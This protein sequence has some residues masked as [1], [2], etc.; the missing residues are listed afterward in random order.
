MVHGT[1]TLICLSTALSAF[2]FHVAAVREE[3][4]LAMAQTTQTP[5]DSLEDLKF[6][7]TAS[8][9]PHM[10]KSLKNI[11]DVDS[12][13][14]AYECDCGQGEDDTFDS[15]FVETVHKDKTFW[16]TG[17]ANTCREEHMKNTQSAFNS[18]FFPLFQPGFF[19]KVQGLTTEDIVE[20]LEKK[21]YS[22]YP[23]DTIVTAAK[24]MYGFF[25]CYAEK[26]CETWKKAVKDAYKTASC[27][28][29]NGK[30]T[31]QPTGVLDWAAWKS[32]ALPVTCFASKETEP[33]APPK[34]NDNAVNCPS[35]ASTRPIKPLSWWWAT[36]GDAPCTE[37]L[38]AMKKALGAKVDERGVPSI[39]M[40]ALFCGEEGCTAA[41]KAWWSIHDDTFDRDWQTT[42][43]FRTAM[44]SFFQC[45]AA[46]TCTRLPEG[47]PVKCAGGELAWG[48]GDALQD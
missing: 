36:E 37:E 4:G 27:D 28:N 2:V 13:D 7:H 32:F 5:P 20:K 43:E 19:M 29:V 47:S 9:M 48:L 8:V 21:P 3:T 10:D 45:Y 16:T 42:H 31:T 41:T 17:D 44:D 39:D 25:A 23:M 40:E 18:L 34:D 26:R 33:M 30:L 1:V 35:K 6:D 11:W 15:N 12:F 46:T 24:E 22:Q 38:V 14:F